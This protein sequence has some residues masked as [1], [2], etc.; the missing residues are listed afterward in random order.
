MTVTL[1]ARSDIFDVLI[2][3]GVRTWSAVDE[4]KGIESKNDGSN[5]GLE[6]L[7]RVSL[8][9]KAIVSGCDTIVCMTATHDPA[10]YRASICFRFSFDSDTSAMAFRLKYSDYLVETPI[11]VFCDALMAL[12]AA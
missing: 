7:K 10:I 11:N 12:E 8:D 9:V 2:S 4:I 3:D 1:Y 6:T 5:V